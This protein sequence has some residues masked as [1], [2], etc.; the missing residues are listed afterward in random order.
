MSIV[1]RRSFIK[2]A[3]LASAA[4][5][6]SAA[7]TG[8]VAAVGTAVAEETSSWRV[9]P[10]APAEVAE[11]ANCDVLVIGLGHAG[12]CA[13]RAAAEQGAL[14][15]AFEKQAADSRSYMSGGQV[16]H[17]N[18]ELLK[19]K[20][21]PEVDE[22]V[23][24]NDWMLRHNNR[25]NPGL[26]RAY[27]ANSGKAFD[28]LFGDWCTDPD[29]ITVRQWPVSD[30]Y[31]EEVG[32]L[33]GFVGCVYTGSFMAEALDACSQAVI[34]NGGTIYHETT[35]YLLITDESGAVT[36][37]YG[38]RE[39][40][41]F[42]KVNASKG[43]ILCGG[44]FGGNPDMLNDL[45]AE[46]KALIPE[47]EELTGGMDQNGSGI[48]LGYW[49]GG[50][51]DPCIGAMGGNYFY[52]CDS[53]SDPAGT[54]PVLWL[55]SQG[56]RY[57]NEGFGSIELAA[58]PG[59]KEPSG[60][61]ATVFGSNVDEYVYAQ[62]PSHM[63]IDYSSEMSQ[64]LLSSL[65]ETM[66]KALAGGANG[67]ADVEEETTETAAAAIDAAAGADAE[68]GVPAGEGGMGGPGGGQGGP[69][70]GAGG[71][72][73]GMGGPGGG[74]TM[75]CSEDLATL[76]GYLG[77]EGEA[78]DNFVASVERYNEMCEAG[79]DEDFAKDP[80]LLIKIEPPYY[81]YSAE[82]E[83]GSPMVTTSGLLVNENSQVLDQHCDPIP[84][85]YA[86]GNNSGSRF[87]YQYTTPISGVSLGFAEAQ[88]Y[89]V[90]N[91][92]GALA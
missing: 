56:K 73:G 3:G 5:A 58:I 38:E 43:V 91:Y 17:I 6:T 45:Y 1:S 72:G 57:C 28:W 81:A 31:Q 44:G 64:P 32:G 35:G 74:V 21:V 52:P 82:R 4:V 49:A 84:G 79:R 75:Y 70:G 46:S 14:V 10:E 29:A 40:G 55:N 90:G 18:S 20:G 26:I 51:I 89:M 60:I 69:G 92:V 36:G 54:A 71:P 48:K 34:D 88:G 23:F 83:I 68:G 87:G 47:G 65:H 86:A 39:D 15:C 42:V 22:L 50:K 30:A 67:S 77:Y 53:P 59:A 8:T 25:C 13:A 27:A 24:M 41:T 61:V 33:R 62:V 7:A 16:G 80:H 85:L 12:S 9:A 37:A 76:A 66:E 78:V 11:E 63:S 19:A 2:G